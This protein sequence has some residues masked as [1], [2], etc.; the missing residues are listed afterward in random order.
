MPVKNEMNSVNLRGSLI[1]SN[2]SLMIALLKVAN[3]LL[4]RLMKRFGS[5]FAIE[6]MVLKRN[7]RS[8]S[9]R[10][11]LAMIDPTANPKEN[12]TRFCSGKKLEISR[13]ADAIKI[14]TFRNEL[15]IWDFVNNAT[16]TNMN[17]IT[18]N[19]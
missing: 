17:V 12:G 13:R 8:L 5:I 19:I 7:S 2:F 16:Q 1:K 6:I 14:E 15:P 18:E 11:T 4:I 3:V 10:K 9:M